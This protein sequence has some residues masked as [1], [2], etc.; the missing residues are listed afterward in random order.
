MNYFI[1]GDIHG[2][3]NTLKKVLKNWNPKDE[4][5]IFVGDYIN[6][7]KHSKEVVQLVRKLQNDYPETICIQGNHEYQM[8]KYIL[9]NT[10]K[11]QMKDNYKN[12]IEHYDLRN[13]FASDAQWM[14][15]LPMFYENNVIY[16][17]HAGVNFLGFRKFHKDSIWSVLR[18]RGKLKRMNKLQ[19]IGHTPTDIGKPIYMKQYNTLNID[20]GAGN[21]DALAA[22]VINTNGKLQRTYVEKIM[23]SDY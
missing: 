7:G 21:H 10:P 13:K 3:V 19:V 12:T 22:V 8:A 1:V 14:H 17:T 5:L 6:K 16:V 20:A 11:H 23:K 4:Q 2:C 15:E 9:Q 18:F